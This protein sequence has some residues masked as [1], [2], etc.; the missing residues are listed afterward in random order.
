MCLT[1]QGN[2]DLPAARE[3]LHRKSRCAR[4]VQAI[5]IYLKLERDCT[6]KAVVPD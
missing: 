1:S 4:L 2:R 6:G 3:R 5:V